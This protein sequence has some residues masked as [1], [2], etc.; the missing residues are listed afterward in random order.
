MAR[1]ALLLL[2]VAVAGLA[3][4]RSAPAQDAPA[5]RFQ[6]SDTLP[7]DP[8]VTLGRL[9]NGL[10]Y[11][12]RVNSRPEQR[13]ELRL[14]V[15][16]GS[17]LEDDDQL[18]LAHFV[19]HMAF[20]GTEHFPKQA[21]VD[22]LEGVGMRFGP[23]LNAYTSFDETVYMLTVPTDSAVILRQAFQIL[24]DWAHLQAFD[25]AE[26][27]LERGVVLEEWRLGRGAEARMRDQQFPVL[28]QGSRYAERLPIGEPE[29]LGAF[30]HEALARFYRDWYR[31]DLMA[32]VAVGDFDPVTIESLIHQHFASVP[33]ASRPRARPLADVPDHRET[34]FA[35][36]TDA[37]ASGTQVA[38][39]FKQPVRTQGTVA[40]Y[41]QGLVEA[42]Y[43]G[44]LNTR[45]FELSQRPDAP[46]LGAFSGQGRVV[47]SKEVYVLGALVR[48]DG[49]T[50]GLTALLT[51]AER[52]AQHGFT[53]SELARTKEELLRGMEQAYAE[54]EKTNS[55]AYAAEYTRAFLEHEPFPGIAY[56]F[57]LTRQLLPTVELH[58]VD[59]L[60]RQWITDGNRV[61]LVS[62]PEKEGL[63]VPDE[64][65]LRAVFTEVM[66]AEITP[67]VDAVADAPLVPEMPR[68]SPVVHEETVEQVGVTVWELANGVRV[69]LKPTDF[70]DDQIYLDSWSPGGTSLV[71]DQDH[72]AA[73]TA[74]A[75]VQR[76]GLGAFSLVE[77][78]KV[79][80]GK[81][82][83]VSP[84]ISSLYEGLS[85]SVSPQDVESLFQLVYLYFTAPRKDPDAFLAYRQQIAARLENRSADPEAAFRDTIQVTLAQYHPRRRPP[86]VELYGEMDLEKSFG[87]Y[88]DRFADASDFSFVLVG[89][90]EPDSLRPLVETYLGGLPSIGRVESWRD[91]GISPPTGVVRKAVRRGVE[92]RSQTV[93]MFTGEWQY[94]R[95]EHYAMR[96]LADVME[97]RLR[98]RL[99]EA[100][101]GTYSVSVGSSGTRRPTEE[102]SIRIS[103]GSAPERVDELVGVVFQQI[104]SLKTVGPTEVEVGKVQEMQ[105]RER[106]TALKQNGFWSRV[107][108]TYDQYGTDYHEILTYE[109][110]V[111]ALEAGTV[112][113]AAR[114]Y[115]RSDNY[116]LVTLYPEMTN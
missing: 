22:Y 49:V 65:E 39:Y 6:L 67:Y 86:T 59:R 81:A 16:A 26:I 21:L 58:E 106:E 7:V 63:H 32:V 44:M 109:E 104:D 48:E 3:L 60:A 99:R 28:F 110:L 98:E 84:Y 96:A 76:G 23:D 15:N 55:A 5:G 78:E 75:V 51:E 36:A 35:I 103:F 68:A 111:D 19:E 43:N 33:M 42:L 29:V 88:Q 92:P 47:R 112:R 31:P 87:F 14:V 105:R 85:G 73:M 107:L 20:N 54:R 2:G 94:G 89:S 38:V 101:G 37:E 18:G 113:D 4:A 13:A 114:R 91:V 53:A 71:A 102:Y 12:I 27:E 30:E 46:F 82:V 61:V 97:I 69:I 79:L 40:D 25:P 9:D 72:V 90:F 8:N 10:R 95:R 80:A 50:D 108:L 66:V 70:K 57:E 17:V 77:L 115:L 34:L 100:L 62:A 93:I 24:E 41:R 11:F 52:V 74:S 1:R 64:A 116:L 56:E 83:S 45:L